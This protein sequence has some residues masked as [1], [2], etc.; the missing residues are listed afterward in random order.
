M[1]STLTSSEYFT[2]YGDISVHELMLKD[3]PRTEA[4]RRALE[5]PDVSLQPLKGKV[6][7][8]VGCGTGILSMFAARAGAKKVYAVDAS[9]MAFTAKRLVEENGLSEVIEVIHGKMEE[10][11]LKGCDEGGVDLI[12]SEWM[13]FYLLHESML[14]SVLYARDKWLRKDGHGIIYPSHATM[15]IAP[16]SMRSLWDEKLVFWKDVYGFNFSSLIPQ[17]NKQDFSPS[18]QYTYLEFTHKM[19]KDVYTMS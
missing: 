9:D 3:R 11:E 14:P 7:L 16:C 13:G 15:S 10:V 18:P 19:D 1:S 4:Y 8:D 17:V 12:V 2:G 5:G 6:V